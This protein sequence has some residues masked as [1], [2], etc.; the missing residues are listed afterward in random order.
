MGFLKQNLQ[1]VLELRHALFMTKFT[2]E[3]LSFQDNYADTENILCQWLCEDVG[4]LVFRPAKFQ[5]KFLVVHQL[6]Y[7]MKPCVDVLG[8]LMKHMI[9]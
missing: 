8:S 3:N 6:S 2:M 9:L 4:K 5:K 7:K 1:N